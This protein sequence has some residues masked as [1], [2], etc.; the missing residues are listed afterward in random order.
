VKSAATLGSRGSGLEYSARPPVTRLAGGRARHLGHELHP[1]GHLVRQSTT[2]EPPSSTLARSPST[3]H[4]T[5][6]ITGNVATVALGVP[7]VAQRHAPGPHRPAASAGPDPL[8]SLIN[9]AR[10]RRNNEPL[11]TVGVAPELWCGEDLA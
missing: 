5:P 10:G 4:R 2:I 11:P 8:S 1:G 7:V 3:A 9:D 6:S